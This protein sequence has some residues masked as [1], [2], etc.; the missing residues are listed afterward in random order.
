MD[1]KNLNN[2][3]DIV[4][5]SESD[6]K[7]HIYVCLYIGE[8]RRGRH[9]HLCAAEARAVAYALLSYAEQISK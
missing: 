9:A 3:D 2:P 6:R 8:D 4:R 5:I 7:G 1:I